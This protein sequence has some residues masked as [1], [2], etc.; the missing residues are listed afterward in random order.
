MTSLQPIRVAFH[1]KNRTLLSLLDLQIDISVVAKNGG[2]D[3][4]LGAGLVAAGSSR[5]EA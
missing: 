4:E 1:F 2:D 3:D 5:S